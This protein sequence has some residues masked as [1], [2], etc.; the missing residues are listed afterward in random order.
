MRWWSAVAIVVASCFVVVAWEV[1]RASGWHRL[2]VLAVVF[3]TWQL[4]IRGLAPAQ[5]Y[6]LDLRCTAGSAEAC[7]WLGEQ[8]RSAGDHVAATRYLE[9]ACDGFSESDA[10]RYHPSLA[11]VGLATLHPER[12]PSLWQRFRPPND[13]R[14]AD[15]A[16]TLAACFVN[17]VPACA[18]A[19]AQMAERSLWC[20][21][22][23][24]HACLRY[25]PRWSSS[26]PAPAPP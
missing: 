15:A 8:A 4:G 12:A 5:P 16:D 23:D 14:A 1:R 7:A 11:C 3:V 22:S 9:L 17:P 20:G 18:E 6:L 24:V 13:A 10:L 26:P 25:A 21:P 2:A 19:C